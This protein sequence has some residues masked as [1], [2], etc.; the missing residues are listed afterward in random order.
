M[1]LTYSISLPPRVFRPT[2]T[3]MESG[4]SSEVCV[5]VVP[6][7]CVPQ[8]SVCVWLQ[9]VGMERYTETLAAAG[10]TSPD[11]LLTLTHQ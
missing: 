9:S 6:E 1:F 4:I 8:W 3:M 11:S 2:S 10:Y 7:V 5:S